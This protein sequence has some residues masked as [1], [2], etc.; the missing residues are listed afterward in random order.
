MP[1]NAG[2]NL[3][4]VGILGMLFF[5]TTDPRWGVWRWMN[6]GDNPIDVAYQAR[7][8][9]IVGLVGSLFVLAVGVWLRSRPRI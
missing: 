9:T 4:I 3:M 6:S 8:G 1:S 7:G 2:R 5:W